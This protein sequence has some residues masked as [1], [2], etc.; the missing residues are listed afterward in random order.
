MANPGDFAYTVKQQADIVRVIGEYVKLRKAGAQNYTGLCPFHGEKTPSFSVHATRQFFHCFG[1]S[2]SGDVFSF[3]QKIENITFPEAVRAVAQKFGI[4]IPQVSFNSPA[5]AREAKLRT[6]LLEIH[7]R[8]C[9]F[10]QECLKRS[11][12]SRAREYLAGRG[13]D[14]ATIRE[15]RIGYAPD[16]GFLLRDRL[17]GEFSEE[18]MR[19]S[20]LFSWKQSE[21]SRQEQQIFQRLTPPRNDNEGRE[22]TEDSTPEAGSE[23]PEAFALPEVALQAMYSKF[24]NRVMFPIASE[25]GRVI[26]FTGR[27]LATDEKAGPKYLNSPETGIYSKSRVLFNLSQAKEAIR[28]LDYAILVEGQMDCISVFAAGFHNVIASSGTAF[29]ELQAK[30]LGRF[31]KNVVVNFDPDTAGAKATERTLGLLTEEEFQIKVLTL[32]AGFD[33]DLYVRRKGKDAYAEALRNS[34]RYFDYLI[35]RART[36]FPLRNAEAKVKAVNYLLPHIQRVP[37]R[38]VRDELS[39][40]I[41]QKLGIDSAILRQELRH[42][43]TKR[44]SAVLKAPVE[45]QA[46]DA[47]RILIRALA[48]ATEMI[49]SEERTSSREGADE[50]F[51]PARQAQFA[52]HSERLHDGLA[53]ESLIEALLKGMPEQSNILELEIPD[54]D[55]NLLAAILMKEEED[56]TAERIEGAVRALRRIQLRR[57]LEQIQNELQGSRN[58]E[59]ERMQALL[60]EKI[61]LKL[62][63]R[64]PGMSDVA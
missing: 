53:T 23:K 47:E 54:S 6:V 57:K 48:S 63:L 11:E 33:P 64:S 9:N 44:S 17:R 4:A 51:D 15:F 35:E 12:G 7:E 41:A 34:Q 26:A 56:L 19:E 50:E 28:K 55:R 22:S 21:D 3:V 10:F 13:L 61:R 45:N 43:A 38:I 5:E 39:H 59:P 52:L 8:A 60:Q 32:E 20:G 62:A 14:D 30:L 18:V 40:E 31:S 58:H 2:A 42:A 46:T 16:S 36:Q 27:T 1:C 24:R 29:T 49:A 25:A 37:N